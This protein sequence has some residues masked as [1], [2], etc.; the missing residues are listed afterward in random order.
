MNRN[1]CLPAL[2]IGQHVAASYA[3]AVLC[4]LTDPRVST[5]RR[6]RFLVDSKLAAAE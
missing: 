6:A 5:R 3:V 2:S 4:V 1:L